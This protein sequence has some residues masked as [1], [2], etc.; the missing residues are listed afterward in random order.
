[1]ASQEECRQETVLESEKRLSRIIEGL[2][3]ATFVIDLNHVITHCNRAYEK[4][5]GFS[6]EELIGTQNHWKAFYPTQRPIL[7]DY[8]VEKGSEE[9]IAKRYMDKYKKSDLIPGA[10]EA[11]D[12]FPNLA[13]GGKWLFFTAAP[14]LDDVGLIVGAIETL[15]DITERKK[16][17][18]ALKKSE[19]RMRALVEFEPY[20][21]VVFTL[22]GRVNYLNPAFTEIFGWTLEELEGKRIPYVPPWL[23]RSTQEGIKR[24]LKERLI[25]RS[26]TQ[27]LTKDGRVLD[28]VIRAAVFSVDPGRAGRRNRHYPG[29]YP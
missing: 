10:Y 19:R 2:S 27:R 23:E 1:M 7:A 20:P 16:V 24:L 12:Y 28:V 26:E 9:E 11:E 5:T 6:A 4:L 22:D 25:L 8:I 17:E 18:E 29:H 21:V 15:Q 14:L 3:I 13:G